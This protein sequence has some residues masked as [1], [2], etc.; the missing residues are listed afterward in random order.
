MVKLF[1]PTIEGII[2][3]VRKVMQEVGECIDNVY[4]AGS[5]GQCRYVEV[6][7]QSALTKIQPDVCFHTAPGE[8][9][10]STVHGALV[11]RC[12]P[13]LV[14]KGTTHA[15][16]GVEC[17]IPFH[18]GV[19]D[20]SKKKWYKD[21]KNYYC[22]D[23]FCTIVERGDVLRNG[24]VY[25]S[26]LSTITVDARE[27]T[28][29]I[30]SSPKTDVRYVTDSDVCKIGHFTLNLSGYGINRTMELAVD[31]THAEIH[32]RCYDKQ[33]PANKIK[34]VVDFLE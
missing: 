3:I 16:Y 6:K 14:P 7:L 33:N 17:A 1:E 12:D 18:S 34:V 9:G 13:S 25:V 24:S 8:S 21:L 4:L 20:E 29:N 28:F 11:L 2:S 22:Q 19:H 31:F 26:N 32:I 27:I 30:Y 5:F 10:L 23:F 15:T